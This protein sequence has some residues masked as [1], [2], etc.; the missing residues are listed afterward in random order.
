[1]DDTVPAQD[2]IQAPPQ[3]TDILAAVRIRA[4]RKIVLGDDLGWPVA[5][6]ATV[7]VRHGTA[8]T[9]PVAGGTTV[10]I[11]SGDD[12][13]P[14]TANGAGVH[15]YHRLGNG[16]TSVENS[17]MIVQAFGEDPAYAGC[18]QAFAA[19]CV[20]RVNG[21]PGTIV[22]GANIIATIGAPPGGGGN[23]DPNVTT[24]T[25]LCGLEID[26]NDRAGVA[27]TNPGQALRVTTNGHWD[28]KD[29]INLSTGAAGAKF[30]NS[31][32]VNE[33]RG[34]REH[35]VWFGPPKKDGPPKFAVPTAG[36]VQLG[37][38][39]LFEN[40]DGAL[41]A[42]HGTAEPILLAPAP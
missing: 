28:V 27:G 15:V 7:T 29:G 10:L 1:M 21:V 12:E 16:G 5:S 30:V 18:V 37:S 24:H 42:Q 11:A 22:F 41:C 19:R 8:P 33:Q 23:I 26:A 2:E 36:G 17:A 9:G 39:Y 13:K 38:W 20:Q 4:D 3:D 6:H 32:F 14:P 25:P 40:A 34:P 35:Y 31:I